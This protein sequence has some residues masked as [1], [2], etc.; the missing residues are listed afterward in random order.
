MEATVERLDWRK[1]SGNKPGRHYY[2][3][4]FKGTVYTVRRLYLADGWS[5]EDNHG[6]CGG[7][8][9]TAQAAMRAVEECL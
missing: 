4:W 3:A 5:I 1:H 8:Y 6:G 2:R 9:K 7:N